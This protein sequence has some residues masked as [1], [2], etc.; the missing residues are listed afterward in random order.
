MQLH[1]HIC[2]GTATLICIGTAT[3]PSKWNLYANGRRPLAGRHPPVFGLCFLP[4]SPPHRK[5]RI[6][7]GEPRESRH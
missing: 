6:S 1:I 7:C 5:V 4:K 3:L 2:I